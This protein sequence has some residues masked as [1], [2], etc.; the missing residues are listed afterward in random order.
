MLDDPANSTARFDDA[1]E[2]P[3]QPVPGPSQP[4][5]PLTEPVLAPPAEEEPWPPI[6]GEWKSAAGHPG[7][8]GAP[9]RSEAASADDARSV[10]VEI[11]PAVKGAPSP[12]KPV[13]QPMSKCP[14]LNGDG[15][16]WMPHAG[17]PAA[18]AETL[19]DP[20]VHSHRPSE[21]VSRDETSAVRP[22][23]ELSSG[24]ASPPTPFGPSNADPPASSLTGRSRSEEIFKPP[25]LPED[26]FGVRRD[27]Q[28]DK[29]SQPTSQN[30]NRRM[31]TDASADFVPTGPEMSAI[32]AT[33]PMPGPPYSGAL[34]PFLPGQAFAVEERFADPQE[35]LHIDA[36]AL[37]GPSSDP[38]GAD[39]PSSTA[40]EGRPVPVL[41]GTQMQQ[42]VS[43][44]GTGLKGFCPV[45][46]RDERDLKDGRLAFAASYHGENYYLASAEAQAAFERNPAKYAP[47]AHGYDL[48]LAAITGEL[49]EGSLDH[50]VW[51]RDRLYLFTSSESLK[52]FAAAPSAMAVTP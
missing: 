11:V 36:C 21:P 7:R 40:E 18:G 25:R 13:T 19:I 1:S 31:R 35:S 28:R 23:D 4:V 16:R 8:T 50:A 45:T 37:I 43:R 26:G 34:F 51:Y 38:S 52:T 42:I 22:L 32:S 47:A 44:D 46:L 6:S 29:A 33:W 12:S 14:F 3:S 17:E 49:R 30:S 27:A 24:F 2:T 9:D 48:A 10:E 41:K 20:T 5:V 39:A 15:P